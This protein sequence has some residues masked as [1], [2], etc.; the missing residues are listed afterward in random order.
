MNLYGK[1]S[2]N[3]YMLFSIYTMWTQLC[4]Y[5]IMIIYVNTV[6]WVGGLYVQ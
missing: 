4:V 1:K 2:L 3:I 6:W 5:I